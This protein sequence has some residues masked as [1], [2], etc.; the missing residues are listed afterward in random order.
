M[1]QTL[2]KLAKFFRPIGKG[3][4][5][6]VAITLHDPSVTIAEI[7]VKSDIIHLENLASAAFQRP[8]EWQQLTRQQE[9]ISDSLRAMYG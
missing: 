8:I 4:D 9:M 7:E 6:V 1:A 5:D 3:S 2:A